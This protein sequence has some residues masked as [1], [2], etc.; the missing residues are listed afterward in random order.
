MPQ[1]FVMTNSIVKSAVNIVIG[2]VFSVYILLCREMLAR[3]SKRLIRAFMNDVW[4][5]RVT[6]VANVSNEIFTKF[7]TGQLTEA[8]I[9]GGLCFAGMVTLRLEYALLISVLIGVT[10]L[11][12]IV[13]AF[14]GAL[15]SAF[16]LLMINPR[17]AVVF[18]V[19]LVLLQQFEGNIIYPR[20]VGGTIGLPAIWILLAITVGGGMFGIL[21]MLLSVPATSVIYR[22][23]GDTVR[24]R[25]EHK[26]Q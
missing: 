16:I 17:D 2:L 7:V 19:F 15:P 26:Q 11:I 12:P 13:G 14:I 4:Y 9:L 25:L 23:L 1:L 21:G 5:D 6:K 24:G 22:L 18:I 20:V 10:S 3:Q 8:L